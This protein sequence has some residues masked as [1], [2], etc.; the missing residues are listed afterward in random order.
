VTELKITIEPFAPEYAA[1]FR[2]LNE[3]WLN[4]YFHIEPHDMEVLSD[5]AHQIVKPGGEIFFAKLDGIVVGTCALAKV[6]QETFEL[7]KMAVTESAQGLG[8]G[9]MLAHAVIK[10]AHACGAKKIFLETNSKLTPALEL[11]RRVGFVEAERPFQTV[12][13]RSNVYMELKL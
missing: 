1:Y 12:Y 11:Y 5:P 2:S 13:E 10:Q 3:E 9:K 6:D 7:A 4:K 8:I